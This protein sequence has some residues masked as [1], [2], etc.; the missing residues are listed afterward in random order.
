MVYR[1]RLLL[2]W[3]PH[4]ETEFETEKSQRRPP[5]TCRV[6]RMFPPTSLGGLPQQGC[7]ECWHAKVE[8]GQDG[9]CLLSGK[10]LQM[11]ELDEFLHRRATYSAVSGIGMLSKMQ[12][13]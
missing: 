10:A 8:T 6:P 11:A 7:S 9:L 3:V 5:R 13:N 2:Y 1:D 4:D 12:H